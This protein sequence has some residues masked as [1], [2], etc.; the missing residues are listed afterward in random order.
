MPDS[1]CTGWR[2][3][4]VTLR[5]VPSQVSGGTGW[6]LD[7]WGYAVVDTAGTVLD[8][9]DLPCVK[10][11]ANNVTITRSRV[12]CRDY[13]L[14]KSYDG[15][16]Y[17]H[18][19]VTD[20]ELDGLDDLASTSIAIM[21]TANSTYTRLDIHDVTSSGPRLDSGDVMQDSYVHDFACG[22]GIHQAGSSMND[23]G[24]NII[25]RH[26]NLD[27]NTTAA[28]CASFAF[29]IARDFGT[30]NGVTVQ[31]NLFNGGAY[32]TQ[33]G[34]IAPGNAY[35]NSVNIQYLGNV[36]GRE[37]TASCGLY[38]PVSEWGAG[39]GNVWSGNTWGGGAAATSTHAIGDP[40]NP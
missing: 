24:G 23:G 6:H 27:I 18:L 16:S 10:V 33:A 12:R 20:T 38:G 29:E 30:Y 39:T 40:V 32:C 2:H 28:G 34:V 9:L 13:Y 25:V 21:G 3:T 7:Q 8:G 35:A 15:T 4:G 37:Y 1:S 19:T 14:I 26:N 11:F 36:F 17:N 31:N 5:A 22:P